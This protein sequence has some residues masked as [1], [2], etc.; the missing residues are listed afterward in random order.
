MTAAEEN[1]LGIVPHNHG[2]DHAQRRDH[3]EA[4][5]RVRG[6]H[7]MLAGNPVDSHTEDRHE[8]EGLALEQREHE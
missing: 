4:G 7:G 8:Y 1:M 3:G 2:S 5:H 6:C